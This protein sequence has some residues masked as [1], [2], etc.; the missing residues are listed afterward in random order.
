MSYEDKAL[1]TKPQ[2]APAEPFDTASHGA[3]DPAWSLEKQLHWFR[4]LQPRPAAEQ[5]REAPASCGG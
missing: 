1:A 5:Q 3:P 2:E 4:R